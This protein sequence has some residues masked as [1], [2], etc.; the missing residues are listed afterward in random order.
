MAIIQNKR[1]KPSQG[2]RHS[3]WNQVQSARQSKQKHKSKEQ[4]SSA[5]ALGWGTLL[6]HWIEGGT[7]KLGWCLYQGACKRTSTPLMWT[8][9]PS[10]IQCPLR[11]TSLQALGNWSMMSRMPVCPCDLGRSVKKSTAMW[12]HGRC[13]IVRGSKKGNWQGVLDCAQ[14]LQSRTSFLTSCNSVGQQKVFSMSAMSI[15][16]VLQW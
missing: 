13:S 11:V 4:V 2:N 9:S 10:Q 5:I 6:G 14:T 7:S 12:N 1:Q 3:S 16:R 8:G 15:E